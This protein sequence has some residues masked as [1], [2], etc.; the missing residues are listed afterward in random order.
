M[1]RLLMFLVGTV[2]LAAPAWAMDRCVV[3]SQVYAPNGALVT[4][5]EV[6]GGACTVTGTYNGVLQDYTYAAWQ[7]KPA[8][9]GAI[10]KDDDRT[11]NTGTYRCYGNGE[12]LSIDITIR[13]DSSYSDGTGARGQLD[14]YS[15]GGIE[16]ASGPFKGYEGEA[17]DGYIYLK[18]PGSQR[19]IQCR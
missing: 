18:A 1:L 15:D 9:D 11:L 8:T 7:L 5:T 16:F 14:Y 6:S 4:V 17:L 13:S 2:L 3:G 12:Y 19:Q 10:I